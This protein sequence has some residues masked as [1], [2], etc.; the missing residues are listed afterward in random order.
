MAEQQRRRSIVLVGRE[1]IAAGAAFGALRRG[2]ALQP[3][4]C[5]PHVVFTAPSRLFPNCL[6]CLVSDYSRLSDSLSLPSP[7]SFVVFFHWG[8]FEFVE[9]LVRAV[10]TK[11]LRLYK[12]WLW[13][14]RSFFESPEFGRWFGIEEVFN[15]ESIKIEVKLV[16]FCRA[17]VSS[18]NH[19]LGL[20]TWGFG[21]CFVGK[22]W[23]FWGD[24]GDVRFFLCILLIITHGL[25][26]FCIRNTCDRVSGLCVEMLLADCTLWFWGSRWLHVNLINCHVASRQSKSAEFQVYLKLRVANGFVHHVMMSSATTGKEFIVGVK[27]KLKRK[28]GSGSFGDIYLGM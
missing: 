15:R 9:R 19:S 14:A 13:F 4:C 8:Q 26:K 28:I 17:I 6:R 7:F 20:T 24:V 11:R 10:R 2:E 16:L 21:G 23:C 25:V 18:S 27:Y 1:E 3:D 12:V 5:S 22:C